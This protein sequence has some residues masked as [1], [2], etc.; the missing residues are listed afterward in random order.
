MMPEKRTLQTKHWIL[1]MGVWL[2]SQLSFFYYNHGVVA[3]GEAGSYIGVVNRM[4]N[5][6]SLAA[7]PRFYFYAVHILLLAAFRFAGLSYRYMYL[8]Q[9]VVAFAALFCFV[10]LLLTYCRHISAVVFAAV[11]FSI[12]PF[13]QIWTSFLY[14]DAN[15]ANLLLIAI[16][17]LTCADSHKKQWLFV[18]CLLLLTFYRPL[19]VL[20]VPVAIVFWLAHKPVAYKIRIVLAAVYA[21]ITGVLI[22][23]CLTFAKGYFYPGHNA[24]A[25]IICGYGSSLTRYI[26]HPYNPDKS[27]V[28][29]LA[30]NPGMTWRLLLGRFFKAFWL[31]RPYYSTLHNII[32]IL[33]LTPFYFFAGTG[34][35]ILIRKKRFLANAFLFCG[36]LLFT[37]PILLFCADWSNRFVLP[38]LVF[39]FIFFGIGADF[40]LSLLKKHFIVSRK[41]RY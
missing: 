37:M 36:L 5:G 35:I 24:E 2:L 25:N 4:F 8:L 30:S 27:M 20:L 14:T 1:I 40:L 34:I 19:G 28:Y 41:G 26:H 21:V 9:L 18:V 6:E 11:V 29:F 3:T 32:F 10:K 23:Y 31:T 16:Y 39:V 13:Y 7:I 15:F 17:L 33:L 22:W 38:A 12:S